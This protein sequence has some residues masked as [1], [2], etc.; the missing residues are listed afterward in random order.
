MSIQADVNTKELLQVTVFCITLCLCVFRMASCVET[1][2]DAE[3]DQYGTKYDK[4]I[5]ELKSKRA[6]FVKVDDD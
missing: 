5:D 1:T 2:P 4:L 3:P 6:R